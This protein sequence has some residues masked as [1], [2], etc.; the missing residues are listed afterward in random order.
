MSFFR[1]INQISEDPFQYGEVTREL[2]QKLTSKTKYIEKKIR[3]Y[4]NVAKQIKL[5]VG[6]LPH[7]SESKKQSSLLKNEVTRAKNKIV[8]YKVILN[9]YKQIG[10]CIAFI[11][12]KKWDIK[13]LVF[14]E[15]PG[16]ISG[17]AGFKFEKKMLNYVFEKELIAIL[18][19]LT[20]CLR[21]ADLTI[22]PYEGAQPMFI[23]AKSSSNYNKR[24]FKQMEE[25]D[26]VANYLATDEVENLYG[27]VGIMNRKACH[28]NETNYSSILNNL[29]SVA[30]KKGSAFKM[31]EKGLGYFVITKF[32]KDALSQSIENLDFLPHVICANETIDNKLS[33][34][35]YPILLT[36][37]D[38]SHKYLYLQ[39]KIV[40]FCYIDFSVVKSHFEKLKLNVELLE[41]CEFFLRI[42]NKKN[43]NIMISTH[44]FSRLFSEFLSMKWMLDEISYQ[45]NL[46]ITHICP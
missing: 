46:G 29:I 31:V 15:S 8:D 41:N 12:I 36:I 40:I 39:S 27:D 45:A 10:D 1:D 3:Y 25:L 26:K 24:T 23:E 20:N 17:K 30:C 21:Y 19:D 37:L 2:Q 11:Y 33:K 43:T 13:P 38:P 28:V 14:K 44:F 32:S 34:G 6:A 9:I 18:N 42:F 5:Q 16:F 35:H 7:N 4:K 22:I